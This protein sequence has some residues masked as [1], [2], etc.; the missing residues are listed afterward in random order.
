VTFRILADATV[1]AH[2]G[3]V[4]FVILGGLLVVRWPRLAWVHVPAAVWGASVEFGGWVCPLTPLENWLRQMGGGAGY[5]ASFVEHYVAG[6]LYPSFLSR[7]LQWLLGGLVV[8]INA[9][10]YAAVFARVRRGRSRPAP[11]R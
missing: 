7:E 9:A 5:D 1:V 8:L 10:V 6:L 2:F 4:L 3:F 11:P